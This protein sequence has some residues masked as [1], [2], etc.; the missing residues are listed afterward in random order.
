[1]KKVYQLTAR[2]L[3]LALVGLIPLTMMGQKETTKQAKPSFDPH[4]YVGANFGLS[5]FHGDITKYRWVPDK[6]NW[7]FGGGLNFGRQMTS[8]FGLRGN[9]SMGNYSGSED[10]VALN[11]QG[12]F[13][14]KI[15]GSYIDYSLLMTFDLD[16]L[17]LGYNP[18]RWMGVYAL[19][20]VGNSQYR[21]KQYE[22]STN[23]LL[24]SRGYDT[25]QG[26]GDGKGF[27]GR[28]LIGTIP[29]GFG[30]NFSVSEK[31]D[32]TLE[33]LFR[34]GDTEGMDMYAGGSQ[35]IKNDFYSLNTIG[36]VYK[37]GAG[38]NLNNMK[39]DFNKV[40]F[41]VIPQV[42]ETKGDEIDVTVRGTFPPNYFVK[43][44]AVCFQPV[45]RY[46]ND[47]TVLAP[48]V[49][50]GENV[51]GEG[52]VISYKNGGTFTYKYTIPY[53][54]E[55]NIAELHVTPVAYL[56]KGP[57]SKPTSCSNLQDYKA[58]ALGDRKLADGVIYTCKRIVPNA[59]KVIAAHG[60]EKETLLQKSAS[61]YFPK[62]KYDVNFKFGLN[63]TDMAQAAYIALYDQVKQGYK[64]K[65]I[66]INGWASPEGEETFNDNLSGNRGGAAKK[67][68]TADM[69]KMKK[70]KKA[71]VKIQPD[72]TFNVTGNGPDWNG[73]MNLVQTSELKDKNT[74]LNVVNSA[75]P[76]K[77]EEEIRNMILI[78]PEIETQLLPPLRR[79]E[80]VIT[81][82]EP[83]KSDEKI[84]KLA[85][86]YPDSLNEKEIMYAATLTEDLKIKQKIY[87]SATQIYSNNW[88]A[89]NNLGVVELM[90][91]NINEA[92]ANLEKANTL[93]PDN[94]EVINNLGAVAMMKKDYDK[95]AQLF[96]KAK[97]LG[98]NE[99]YNLGVLMVPKGKYDE[100][101]VA[102]KG[103]KCD[104]NLALALM[105]SGNTGDAAK[106][107][108]CAEKNAQTYYLKAVLGARTNNA[109]MLF[110]NLEQAV[111]ADAS[112]KAT[113]KADRE[114]IK[115][116]DTAEFRKI[117]E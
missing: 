99:S 12:Y 74:I 69:D 89:F 5:Q 44:A 37:F 49:L 2:V 33:S 53:K 38:G 57:V 110:E 40:K 31:V 56:P 100:A 93:S 111:K 104:Y 9:V 115:F 25:E 87:K 60:Y 6:D 73:F 116:M 35:Q 82:F 55:M 98:M 24:G 4:W 77:K 41:D 23:T 11:Y 45:L 84:A 79:A 34:I 107:L 32:I 102:M 117:A 18:D 7:N 114:F 48:I 80:I 21:V 50:R 3:I 67:A 13:D 20:G 96:E 58:L 63:K 42:L 78:Y 46:G 36:L 47:S 52:D 92:S 81:V 15:E 43:N 61:I 108:D 83:K 105:L 27:G 101:V 72:I 14:K 85:V 66:T 8:I 88:K 91:G 71:P 22:L 68:V 113:A 106:V 109:T 90:L 97:K 70:D 16:N 94:A 75:D 112:L 59:D 62:N 65:D 19:L 39:R 28:D 17:I 86:T 29:V 54:P 103:K 1:M 26:G 30:F 64:I 51:K 95:A 76:K 10:R